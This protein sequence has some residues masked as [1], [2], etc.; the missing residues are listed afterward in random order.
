MNLRS[1]R[2]VSGVLI[3]LLAAGFGVVAYQHNAI[4][5]LRS[6][7]QALSGE[8]QEAAQLA[9]QNEGI[10]K[11]REE[12]IEVVK[13]REE[14]KDLPRLRNQARQLRRE[15]DEFT[16][17]RAENERL[18]ADINA[19]GPAAGAET[20]PPDFISRSALVDAGSGSPEATVQ[21]LFWATCRGNMKRLKQLS[22]DE[23]S[24]AVPDSEAER[25]SMIDSMK[26]FTGFRIA[27]KTIISPDEVEVHL[28]S[29]IDGP[30]IPMKLKRAGN[31]WQIEER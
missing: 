19:P 26:N 17:L 22:S 15:M 10:A 28:Q 4:S 29:S 8:T 2:A 31:E 3:L 11:L 6:Q 27:D 7:E 23:D 25:K 14:N 18:Q 16:K 21:T 1:Q 30:A 20:L 13:L 12:N 5:Q 24:E 9:G